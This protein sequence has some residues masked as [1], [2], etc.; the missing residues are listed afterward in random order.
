MLLR[1]VPVERNPMELVRIEG[2]SRRKREPRVLK[3]EQ[4]AVLLA[5]LR[6]PYRTMA[7]LAGGLGLRC[8]EFSGLKWVDVDFESLTISL[9]QAIVSGHTDE[10]KTPASRSV[11]PIAPELSDALSRWKLEAVLRNQRIGFS[12][13]LWR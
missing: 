1:I 5:E 9:R 2:A 4:F 12:R 8:S 13:V 3:Y 7:L 10:L 6:E 11:L